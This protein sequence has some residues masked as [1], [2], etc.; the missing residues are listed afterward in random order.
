MAQ[1]ATAGRWTCWH[2]TDAGRPW[3]KVGDADSEA[4][5]WRV[6]MAYPLSGDRTV[7]R[8]GRDPNRERANR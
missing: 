1:P 8:P 7:C 6:M 2:R 4:E 3:R 5:A